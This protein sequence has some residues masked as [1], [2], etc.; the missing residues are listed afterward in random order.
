M[1]LDE[2]RG[3]LDDIDHQMLGLLAQRAEVILEV[4]DLKKRLGLPV[5]V[6]E[7]ETAIIDRLRALNPGP[8]DGDAV[9]RIY[10]VIVEE[11]RN[12]EDRHLIR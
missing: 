11:M 8:I 12:F 10:R 9:E 1:N 7:R 2:L 6:P 5:H 4:A 3:R